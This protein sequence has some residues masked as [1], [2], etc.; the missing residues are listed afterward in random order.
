MPFNT[1]KISLTPIK[2]EST[3][4]IYMSLPTKTSHEIWFL[5]IQNIPNNYQT[6]N[7]SIM[8]ITGLHLY[9]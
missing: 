9:P 6:P 5:P 7:G 2:P 8:L 4:Q 1:T 3:K